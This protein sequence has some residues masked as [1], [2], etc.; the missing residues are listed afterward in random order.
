M[1]ILKKSG[2][3]LALLIALSILFSACGMIKQGSS[4]DETKPSLTVM[5]ESISSTPKTQSPIPKST[6]NDV[7]KDDLKTVITVLND[8]LKSINNKTITHDERFQ[9]TE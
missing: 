1:K 7:N 9:F 5:P 6:T 3:I 8:N 2:V 4:V